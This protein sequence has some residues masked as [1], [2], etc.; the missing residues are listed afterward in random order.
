MARAENF[1][2]DTRGGALILQQTVKSVVHGS[3]QRI[4]QSAM[5]MS[6]A[7]SG[8]KAKLKVV[9]SIS[10]LQGKGNSDRYTATIVAEDSETEAQMRH[11]N[12]IAKARNAGRV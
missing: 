10:P 5:A 12:Y 11:G 8:H 3:A 7:A 6:G 4:A 9:G 1:F 2:L